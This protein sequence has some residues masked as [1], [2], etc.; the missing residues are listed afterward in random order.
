MSSVYPGGLDSFA[1]DKTNDT[2]QEDDHP[3]HHNDLADAVNKIEA[4]LGTNPSAGSSTV[5]DRIGAAETALANHLADTTDAHDAA[6]VSVVDTGGYFTSTD[7]EGALQELG[8][9]GGGG[10]V[11]TSRTLTAG[12]GLTGGG[13]LT[14]DRTFDVNP[15]NSTLEVNADVLRVKA[16]GITAAHVA[17]DVATQAE[18]DA[19]ITDA[20]A[21][22]AASA[23]AVTPTG[24]L[25]ADDAQEALDEHQGDIDALNVGLAA[26]LADTTDAH[27]ASAISFTPTGTLSSTDVQAAIAELLAETGTGSIDWLDEG[28]SAGSRPAV[29]FHDGANITITLT[30]D[31]GNDEMDITIAASAAASGAFALFNYLTA[32]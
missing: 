30:D 32:R 12:A 18:L 24:N 14:A 11:P 13:D 22:H 28:V 3:E 9:G 26:H 15:D 16:N 31:P 27:D 23:I 25:A 6:A 21:A 7:V 2:V 20:T 29:N 19:H 10:G 17:A 1:T 8:A 4:E 5:A